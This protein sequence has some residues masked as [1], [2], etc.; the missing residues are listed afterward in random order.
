MGA[1]YYETEA[2]AAKLLAE[3]DVP[4]GIG[5]GSVVQN[6]IIDKNARIGKNVQIINKE[7]VQEAEN[8][9]AGYWIKSGIITIIKGSTIPD[10]TV[11]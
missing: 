1:D 6:C 8:E 4:I 5:E 10:G 7:N 3:G 9:A 11:I 2:E